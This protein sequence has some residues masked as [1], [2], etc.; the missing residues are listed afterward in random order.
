[1][2]T[3]TMFLHM[4]GKYMRKLTKHMYSSQKPEYS[5]TKRYKTLWP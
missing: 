3:L 4:T 1:M 5:V 2:N